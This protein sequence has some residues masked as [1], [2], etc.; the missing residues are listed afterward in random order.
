MHPIMQQSFAVIDQEIGVHDFSPEEYAI[1]RRIIHSTADFEFKD[2]IRF[3]PEAIATAIAQLSRQVPIVTDVSMVKQGILTLVKQTFGNP[4]INAIEQVEAAAPGKTRTE[5]GILKCF[6]TYPEALFVIGNAP[7]A[8]L[9]LCQQV[10][11][12]PGSIVVVGTPVGFIS[13]LESKATLAQ[14]AIPQI[15]IEG[16]KGGSAVA[17][18]IVNALLVLAWEH[19]NS[20]VIS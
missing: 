17:A 16:R 4:V 11:A 18:A 13:V 20:S 7:T 10:Q 5:T 6:D 9:A 14:T 8:L 1:V 12:T 15:R 19:A 2:L 3:S